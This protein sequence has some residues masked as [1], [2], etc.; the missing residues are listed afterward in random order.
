MSLIFISYR[1]DDGGYG[2]ALYEFLCH[3][4]D[5][6]EVFYDHENLGPGQKFR[7]E[8]TKAI[9]RSKVFLAVIGPH[10]FSERNRQRLADADDTTRGEIQ[11]ALEQESAGQVTII[12]VL[13]GGAGVPDKLPSEIATLCDSNVY[14]LPE[15]QYRPAQQ[16]LLE[17]LK[18]FG[19]TPLYRPGHG[20]TQT[21]HTIDHNLT[22][23]FSDPVG[24]LP[25]LYTTLHKTGQAAVL[26]SAATATLHG[27]GG[28]G[29]TQLALKYSWD[30]RDEYAGVWWFRA[31][32][33]GRLQQDCQQFC[34]RCG[35][36]VYTG[37]K[38]HQA[39]KR[40]LQEQPSWLL[41]YDNAEAQYGEQKETLHQFLPGSGHHV[42]IT[43]RNNCWEGLAKPIE[44]DVWDE[45][46][47]LEFLRKRLV[48][49]TDEELRLLSRAL[50]GLPLALEQACAY[51]VWGIGRSLLSGVDGLGAG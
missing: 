8:L 40:W 10:W 4:Y 28:V 1:R 29:K 12:P 51:I 39:V 45:E 24:N 11:T 13:C 50:G 18:S 2:R 32:D 41:V 31:E 37:E 33:M 17:H 16:K 46:Q 22:P 30:F 7:P 26:A 35:I 19:L 9:R 47:A 44:L 38:H 15:S 48:K 42:L 36:Q 23:Y 3:W 5:D 49:A 20:T 14:H 27:M 6:A 25:L 34:E 43:S 21:F